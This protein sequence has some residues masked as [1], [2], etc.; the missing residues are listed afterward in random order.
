MK[1]DGDR[2]HRVVTA[3]YSALQMVLTYV[4]VCAWSQF[5][6]QSR[7]YHHELI[8]L[9]RSRN[10]K[11]QNPKMMATNHSIVTVTRFHLAI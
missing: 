8:P 2:Q 10:I 9:R 3:P 1:E 4:F 11:T 5:Q 6:T 7:I